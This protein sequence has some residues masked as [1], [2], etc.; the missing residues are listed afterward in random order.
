VAFYAQA[1]KIFLCCSVNYL[2]ILLLVLSNNIDIIYCLV[3]YYY[4]LN[5][6]CT[7]RHR[8]PR[9]CRTV[10]AV[11]FFFYT[12]VAQIWLEIN[13]HFIC[14]RGHV[15]WISFISVVRVL[16]RCALTAISCQSS[17]V[18]NDA[19][20]RIRHRRQAEN[21]FSHTGAPRNSTRSKDFDRITNIICN[22]FSVRNSGTRILYLYISTTTCV[23]P[24]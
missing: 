3:F 11:R 15:F 14:G 8:P 23:L 22:L 9:R 19:Q 12:V 7:P 24:R 2:I 18:V 6:H 1:R 16:Y 17:L 20:L 13:F 5:N 10:E 21:R 4:Y